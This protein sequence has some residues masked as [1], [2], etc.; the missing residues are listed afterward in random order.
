MRESY[1]D[2]SFRTA[3]EVLSL[4]PCWQAPCARMRM[5]YKFSRTATCLPSCSTTSISS[6]DITSRVSPKSNIFLDQNLNCAVSILVPLGSSKTK[7]MNLYR[8]VPIRA[9]S[10]FLRDKSLIYLESVAV[11]L[12]SCSSYPE[13]DNARQLLS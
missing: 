7:W 9:L 3:A 6:P 1:H 5:S 4:P 2:Q 10:R 8:S 13:R 12:A 11:T